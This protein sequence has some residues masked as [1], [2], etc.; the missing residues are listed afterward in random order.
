MIYTT[1]NEQD[2]HFNVLF[3]ILKKLK[4]PWAKKLKHLSYGWLIYPP[5]K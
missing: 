5:V 4:Y 2:Y 3:E 1:G